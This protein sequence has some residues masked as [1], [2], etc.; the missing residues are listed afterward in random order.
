MRIRKLCS[1]FRPGRSV[2][3]RDREPLGPFVLRSLGRIPESTMFE[4][5]RRRM[6]LFQVGKFRF[7][8]A[9]SAT[10]ILAASC[11]KFA[12][13]DDP[14]FSDAGLPS[15]TNPE[16]GDG[17]FSAAPTP[18]A[19]APPVSR[20]PEDDDVPDGPPVDSSP[21]N[22]PVPAK[23]A[24][25]PRDAAPVVDASVP[26]TPPP[27][28][29]TRP[30]ECTAANDI[31]RGYLQLASRDTPPCNSLCRGCCFPSGMTPFCV[32]PL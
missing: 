18:P 22:P 32:K 29:S 6:T 1:L 8:C 3:R 21:S 15:S 16:K 25:P 13:V 7:F 17:A 26:P 12:G 20:S 19:P 11:G 14:L 5:G 31:Q 2:R 30:A 4:K 10:A 27:D 9:V 24:A 23:D 28:A